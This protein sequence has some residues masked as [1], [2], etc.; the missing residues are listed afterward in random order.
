MLKKMSL[1]FLIL[2]VSFFLLT[3]CTS[4]NKLTIKNQDFEYLKNGNTTKININNTRDKGFKFVITDEREIA[5]IYE[6]LSTAQSV[7]EKSSLQP[8]YVF[9]LY[10]EGNKINKFYYI[11]GL[12]EKDL[13]NFYSDDKIY[14]VSKTVDTDII[15]SF[16]STRRPKNF[17]NVYYD[18]ILVA[19]DN[20]RKNV[21]KTELIGISLKN[22]VEVAKFILSV[23]LEHFSKEINEKGYNA[24]II[25][26]SNVNY[27]ITMNIET[28]GYKTDL[29]KNEG[30]Y[31][32]ILTFINKKDNSEKIYYVFDNYKD[33]KW[34]IRVDAEKKPAGF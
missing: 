20:Y 21:D 25:S 32:S 26:D 28:K 31:K 11:A 10:T 6:L 16:W 19:I 30:V 8:D 14:K 12:D 7:K 18:S 9:E 3:G 13:G 4:I 29:I 23:D 27:G 33:G 17:N 22:D 1:R 2:I 24:T 5:N 15:S 34:D